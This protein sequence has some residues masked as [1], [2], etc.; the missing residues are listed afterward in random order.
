MPPH[1]L[2]NFEIQMNFQNEPKFNGVFTRNKLPTIKDGTYVI[3]LD[4][5]KSIETHWIALYLNGD[6]P[7]YFASFG[8]EHI[9]KETKKVHRKQKFYN[10]YL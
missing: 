2:A 6:N 9:T 5:F 8:V 7:T 10:K 4:E 3:I 1:P